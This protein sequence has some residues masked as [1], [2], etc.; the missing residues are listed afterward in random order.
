MAAIGNGLSSNWPSSSMDQMNSSCISSALFNSSSSSSASTTSPSVN[1]VGGTSSNPAHNT[2]G[3][4]N[5]SQSSAS[6]NNNES[7]GFNSRFLIKV[8]NN[9]DLLND[10]NDFGSHDDDLDINDEDNLLDTEDNEAMASDDIILDNDLASVLDSSVEA[11]KTNEQLLASRRKKKRLKEGITV[12]IPQY[13]SMQVN[14]HFLSSSHSKK[15]D[16]LGINSL[17][18]S[19]SNVSANNVNS[20]QNSTSHRYTSPEDNRLLCIARRLNDNEKAVGNVMVEQFTTRLDVNGKVVAIDVSGLTSQYS[21]FL[22]Q[23]LVN[24]LIQEFVHPDDLRRVNSHLKEAI[25]MSD[26]P[27][28]SSLYRFKVCLAFFPL[29]Q[30]CFKVVL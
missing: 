6:N 29:S 3:N 1:S 7:K 19:S 25:T 4:A 8:D 5:S 21:Q 9:P 16:S 20:G 17:A 22:N 14:T 11:N 30:I 23:S 24:S 12:S 27:A 10:D 26:S 28:S 15:I 18:H 13:E 2:S